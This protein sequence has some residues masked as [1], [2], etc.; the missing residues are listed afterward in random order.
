MAGSWQL[1]TG[2]Y[3]SPVPVALFISDGDSFQPTGLTRSFW[4][5]DVQH[6]GPPVGLL[7][8]AIEHIPTSVPMQVV[9][10]SVDLCRPVPVDAPIGTDTRVVRDGRRIQVVD[11]S[12]LADGRPV[13]RA[14]ALK[15]RTTD[16]PLHRLPVAWD[17]PAGPDEAEPISWARPGAEES[18]LDFFHIHAIEIRT[19]D[20]SLFTLGEGLSWVRL[21]VPV[22]DGEPT[23][24]FVATATLSDVGN[25]NS[26]A[27]DGHRWLYVNPDLSLTLHR[28][29]EDD[30]LGMRSIAHQHRSGIGSAE[31]QLFDAAGPV[32]RVVQSQIL[33]PRTD[34]R[35]T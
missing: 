3:L 27:L 29:P 8:R 4:S 13:A 9:R 32:G 5:D 21:A 31:S 17:A 35:T 30:W 1:A 26:M 12:L 15:I 16:V 22:V 14:S 18:E 34:S 20:G 28:L 6:G 10:L 25:G 7:A 24:P 33:E 2:D 19:V 11:A 23:S